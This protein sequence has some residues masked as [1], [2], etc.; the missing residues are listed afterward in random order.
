[1]LNVKSFNGSSYNSK[2]CFNNFTRFNL[3]EYGYS[4]NNIEE[5]FFKGAL[6][7]D[8]V[9]SILNSILNVFYILISINLNE[10]KN[11]VKL[12]DSLYHYISKIIN[13]THFV[14]MCMVK[15]KGSN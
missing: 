13:I 4:W 9:K 8:E 15:K 5:F 14:S 6:S 3:V 11:V 7:Q 2:G 10:S 1:M 12:I